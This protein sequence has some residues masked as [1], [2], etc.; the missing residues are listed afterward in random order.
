MMFEAFGFSADSHT[1]EKPSQ[2]PSSEATLVV[3]LVLSEFFFF[4]STI[5]LQS[6]IYFSQIFSMY[7]YLD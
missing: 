6:L 2:L 1:A 4:V 7:S 5:R 3:E